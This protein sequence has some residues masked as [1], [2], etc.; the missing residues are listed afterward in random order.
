MSNSADTQTFTTMSDQTKQCTHMDSGQKLH[1]HLN[2]I[3]SKQKQKS[4]DSQIS[5][6]QS[7]IKHE[8]ANTFRQRNIPIMSENHVPI[9]DGIT[10]TPGEEEDDEEAPYG[11]IS[12]FGEYFKEIGSLFIEPVWRPRDPR[13]M[14]RNRSHSHSSWGL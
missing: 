10:F 5:G 7:K 6:D 4:R 2:S 13:A 12:S 11:C 8:K 1:R 9:G 3:E 14:Y